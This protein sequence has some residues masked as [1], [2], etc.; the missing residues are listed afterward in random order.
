MKIDLQAANSLLDHFDSYDII[1]TGEP[2]RDREVAKEFAG[3]ARVIG[4]SHVTKPSQ[5][6]AAYQSYCRSV[7]HW[8]GRGS[9][10]VPAMTAILAKCGVAIGGVGE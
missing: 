6:Q 8:A 10:S 5:N 7:L 9:A 3:L 1:H 4:C 2:A